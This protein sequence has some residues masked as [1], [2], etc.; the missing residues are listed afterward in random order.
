VE[1]RDLATLLEANLG[2]QL[3]WIGSADSKAVFGF[4]LNTAMLGFLAAVAPKS[5]TNW[6]IA[7]AVFASFAAALG[8]VSLLF[9][10][11]AAFP[12]TKGPKGSLIYCDGVSQRSADQF[13]QAILSLATEAYVEDL[14]SQ[15]HRNAEIASKKFAWVQ[16]AL[17]CLYISVPPWALAL[18]LLYS[19]PNL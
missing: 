10:S 6:T 15:C 14:A 8:L 2:R 13:K 4:A 7:P 1:P 18:W 3:Y 9:L 5:A 12:R 11:F 17:L 19:A 16:R